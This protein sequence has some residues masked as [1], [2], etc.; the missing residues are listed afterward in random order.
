MSIVDFRDRL[1]AEQ[2]LKLARSHRDS[3]S[4]MAFRDRMDANRLVREYNKT[5]VALRKYHKRMGE[6]SVEKER[7]DYC[8]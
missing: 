8:I 4:I 5:Q 6:E 2:A 7:L 1:D 3:D